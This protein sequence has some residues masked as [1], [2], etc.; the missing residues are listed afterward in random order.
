MLPTATLLSF[1]LPTATLPTI[2]LPTLMLPM[3]PT[4]TLPTLTLPSLTL[5]TATLP[6][7]TLPTGTLPTISLPTLTLPTLT[8]PTATLPT[9]TLPSLTPPTATLPLLTLPTASLPSFTLAGSTLPPAPS[10][11]N[12]RLQPTATP[13]TSFSAATVPRPI[14]AKVRPANV[15]LFMGSVVVKRVRSARSPILFRV[16]VHQGARGCAIVLNYWPA[17][18]LAP[19]HFSAL[20][21]LVHLI[22]HCAG[23]HAFHDRHADHRRLRVYHC[24]W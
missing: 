15:Q 18:R 12:L 5:P 13:P 11:S 20:K 6:S 9:L 23:S 10:P 17:Q 14:G 24:R 3:L 1:T 21:S 2:S 4:A 16:A 22:S 19:L 8:L 7:F